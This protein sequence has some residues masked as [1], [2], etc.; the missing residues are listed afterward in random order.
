MM[1]GS[2]GEDNNVPFCSLF[3][4]KCCLLVLEDSDFGD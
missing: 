4:G 2:T 1:G 3:E